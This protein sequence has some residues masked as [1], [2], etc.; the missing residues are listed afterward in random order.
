MSI[1]IM[2]ENFNPVKRT[3]KNNSIFLVTDVNGNV[4][5]NNNSGYGLYT[6][7]TR[8]LS[9]LEIK[10]ND[11][12]PVVLSSSTETGHSS[13]IISTNPLMNDYYNHE[14]QILQETIQIK[15]ESI[16]Y[17]SYF[18]TITI[19]N[20]NLTDINIK[21]EIIF[22]SDFLDIFEVRNIA[23]LTKG[24]S[25]SPVYENN[26]LK[27]VYNDTTG[28]TLSTEINF[29]EAKPSKVEDCRTIFEFSLLPNTQQIIKYQIDLKSTAAL[30]SKVSAYDFTD[31]F[32]KAVLQESEEANYSAH[33]LSNNED[34]NEMLQ[35]SYK[36][37]NMLKTNAYYGEYIA[38]GI[39]W[40]TTL[41]GRDSIITALQCLMLN[42]EIAKNTLDVLAI[43][44]GKEENPWKDEEPG[45]ILHE[46]RFGELARVN[47]IP[48]SPYYGTIDATPLWI[49]LLYHYFKWTNDIET[50][51]LLW[52]NALDCLYWMDNYGLILNGFASYM[53]K[54]DDGLDNQG[55][56]DS[57]N[58]NIHKDGSLAQPP[59]AP[60]EVQGYFYAAKMHMAE[61]AKFLGESDLSIRLHNEALKFKEKFQKYFWQE[62]MQFYAM[63]LDKDLNPMKIISS[64]PGHCL[65]TGIVD[66]NYANIVAE[67]FFN[68]DMFTGWG[69]RT[70]SLS[71]KSFNPMSYHNGSIWPHD[72]SIIAYGISHMNRPD[73]TL[74]ITTA[75]FE[76][77]RLMY[78]K[79]LPELFCGFDRQ[80]RRQDP[81]VKYPVACSPQAWAAGSAFLL[82]QSM[83]N[84]VPDA[85]NSELKLINSTMPLW[86]DYLR[87]ENLRIGNANVS[88]EFKKTS[89]GMVI[90][91]FNKKGKIDIVIIK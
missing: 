82:V 10:I 18:E 27:F 90:D 6:D 63:G 39:P 53:K 68:P 76:S 14:K 80:Y 42:P 35:R 81:P 87:I 52:K 22:E 13:V 24:V 84:I 62:D 40:F 20:Y 45:K 31:A 49:I 33:F 79:R 46:M 69:I 2:G 72:N 66:E 29:I 34:F 21:L 50:L 30:H 25:K 17:G 60:V 7:D 3:I 8:F 64:N 51:E 85:Q 78:Y 11:I 28:A 41:F 47:K 19:E 65:F 37:I 56:K 71:N 43:F 74:R 23:D 88:F 26:T 9:R 4:L 5:S 57:W 75:L 38:A 70:L 58:S 55:W 86:L 91:T 77:A 48:H 15:R 54:S 73:L 83:L 16:I 89:N 61:L 1:T 67:R 44:Q 59:I 36:D 12:D 32:E